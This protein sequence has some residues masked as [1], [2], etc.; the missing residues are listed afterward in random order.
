MVQQMSGSRGDVPWPPV[1]GELEVS[2]EEAAWLCAKGDSHSTPIA[3]PVAGHRKAED[4]TETRPA[5]EDPKTETRADPK[6]ETRAEV[7]AKDDAKAD[8][9]ARDEAADT[10]LPWDDE[11][12]DAPPPKKGPGRPRKDSLPQ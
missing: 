3:V 2:D 6:T 9:E 8:A 4:K 10:S 12:A 1:G 7:R 11:P 5:P